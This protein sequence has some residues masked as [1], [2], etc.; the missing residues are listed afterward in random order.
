MLVLFIIRADDKPEQ[1]NHQFNNIRPWRFSNGISSEELML[2]IND[3]PIQAA[4]PN[5]PWSAIVLSSDVWFY[6]IAW[7]CATGT[8]M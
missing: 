6:T 2:L 7:F 1:T 4:F 3:R 5:A 8:S